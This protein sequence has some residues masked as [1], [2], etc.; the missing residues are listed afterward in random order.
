MAKILFIGDIVGRPGR[1]A[2]KSIVPGLRESEEL[3]LVIANG[4][5]AAG[6]SGITEAIAKELHEAGVDGITLGDH[7]WDQRGWPQEI[8]RCERVCRPANLPVVTPGR[9]FLILESASGF[10]LGVFTLLGGQYMKLEAENPFRVVDRLLEQLQCEDVHALLAEI[11]AEATSEKV[12]MGWKLNGKVAAV[13]GTHTHIPTADGRILSQ[14][15][16][17]LTDVGMTGPYQSVLGREI[18]PILE[19]FADGMPRRFKVATKDARLCGVLLEIDP[20]T[21]RCTH[22]KRLELKPDDSE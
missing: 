14:G 2:V 11:H 3:D 19:R 20:E 8:D 7:V 13:L 5:N 6:G 9:H 1:Q 21:G 15:T 16:G 17:Y 10:R 22:L 18:R 12:A 4:E